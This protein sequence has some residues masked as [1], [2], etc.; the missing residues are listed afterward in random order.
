MCTFQSTVCTSSCHVL[1]FY[2]FARGWRV[3]IGKGSS[4]GLNVTWSE[5]AACW[6]S[7]FSWMLRLAA[8][9]CWLV[10]V[11]AIGCCCWW[12]ML[13][14]TD[15]LT[16]SLREDRAFMLDVPIP[17]ISASMSAC[18]SSN[19]V[20]LA[21]TDALITAVSAASI[22]CRTGSVTARS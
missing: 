16:T 13:V 12:W 14:A 17:A 20:L 9:C 3:K 11:G 5:R 8:W 7:C 21:V 19:F 18:S 2:L 22:V 10:G 6:C 15:V 4:V 1:L